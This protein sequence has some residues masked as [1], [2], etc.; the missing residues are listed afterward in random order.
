MRFLADVQNH[1]LE[2]ECQIFLR[3]SRILCKNMLIATSDLY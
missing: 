3:E 1:R 2:K